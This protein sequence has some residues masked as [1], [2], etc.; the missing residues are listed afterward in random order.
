[1][2]RWTSVLLPLAVGLIVLAFLIP[3]ALAVLHWIQHLPTP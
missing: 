2:P 1:M 3:K